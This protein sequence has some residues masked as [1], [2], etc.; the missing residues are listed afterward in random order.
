LEQ[1]YE[2]IE[3][4]LKELVNILASQLQTDFKKCNSNSNKLIF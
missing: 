2:S 3:D 1:K 4:S